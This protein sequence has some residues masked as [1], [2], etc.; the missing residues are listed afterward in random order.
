MN[1]AGGHAQDIWF[2]GEQNVALRIHTCAQGAGVVHAYIDGETAR[3]GLS[4]RIDAFDRAGEGV[5]HAGRA[6]LHGLAMA[7]CP[8]CSA[9]IGAETSKLSSFT[10]EN[11]TEPVP[12]VSPGLILRA[13]ITPLM[14]ALIRVSA[15]VALCD[16]EGL[17]RIG[18]GA[19]CVL[20]GDFESLQ[21]HFGDKAGTV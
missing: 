21:G 7:I 14:G 1:G 3:A 16:D 12:T 17:L 6:Q 18:Q 8:T 20:Q 19:A 15:K 9:E 2:A 10:M 4:R 11:N 13:A 5:N